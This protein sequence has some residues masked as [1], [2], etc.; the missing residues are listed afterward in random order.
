MKNS[1]IVV[2]DDERIVAK[3]IQVKLEAFGFVV[4]GIA[5]SSEE[6]LELVT[7]E[8]PDLVLMDIVLRGKEDG[9]ETARRIHEQVDVPIVYLTAYSDS[10]TLERAKETGPYGYMLKPF[11]EKDLRVTVE[12]A[13]YKHQME[14]RLKEH[15]QWLNTTLESIGDGVIA[16][17]VT[18]TIKFMNPSAE[19]LTGWNRRDV[20]GKDL[21]DVYTT[22]SPETRERL[23]DPVSTVLLEGREVALSNHTMVRSR[24]GHETPIL[25]SGTPI[26]DSRGNIFGVVLAFRDMS[27]H[28]RAMDALRRSEDRYK[29]LFQTNPQPMWV[30]DKE[31]LAFL[32]VNPA[33][34]HSYGYTVEEFR[35]MTLKDIRPAEDTDAL[36]EDL[37][38]GGETRRIWRHKKKDGTL[39]DVEV[40][41][42]DL[43][44]EN[45][46][47]RVALVID[48]SER[49]KA[50]AAIRESEAR[51]RDVVDTARDAIFTMSR[52]AVITSLNPAFE[53]LTGFPREQWIGRSFT[54]LL[55][56]DDLPLA[57]K[58]FGQTI[59]GIHSP[60]FELRVHTK[61][62]DYITGEFVIAPR[63]S[64]GK[65]TGILGVARDITDRRKL[66]EHLRES[67]KLDSV[68]TLAGG[69]A[70]DF[71]NILG[72]IL[73]YSTLMQS[74]GNDPTTVS[75]GVD[76]ISKAVHRGAGVV[77]QLLTFARKSTVQ[78]EAVNINKV[79][80][81]IVALLK[82]TFPRSIVF[83]LDLME[84]PPQ[85]MG[86]QNQLDQ[87]LLNLS[88]NARDAMPGGGSL[89]FSTRLVSSEVVSRRIAG[90]LAGDYIRI[91]VSDT[92][93]GMDEE[94][95]AHVFEPFFT[96][97]GP[98]AGTGLGLSVVYGVVRNHH[99][100]V[101]VESKV[102]EGST[103]HI[104]LPVHQGGDALARAGEDVNESMWVGSET[105]LLIEDEIALL[106]LLQGF[107]EEKGYKVISA[108]TG[109]DG[110][111]LYEKHHDEIALVVTDVG[112][113][114]LSGW[115][116]Y[117]KM[118][119]IDPA[120]KVIFASGYLDPSESSAR[121]TPGLTQ[122]I[123]KPYHHVEVL[124]KIRALLDAEPI[125]N[126]E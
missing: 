47:A 14:R 31:T 45:H 34:V 51:Y 95:R 94:T 86:D 58:Q 15:E 10:Q 72:I 97:K 28:H 83:N 68:G 121:L 107:I 42:H 89:S 2:V 33:A 52:D 6:A 18:G 114:G 36:I 123:E 80:T 32:A 122:T 38:S 99:G 101:E 126:D 57:V 22:V 91:S 50:V 37:Q 111:A 21:R 4:P 7:R 75:S 35:S 125:K 115:K 20:L 1:R 73:G 76:A 102:G 112:L 23:P 25:Q 100:F 60:V 27:E 90:P 103:F 84:H 67:Q 88:L 113:P 106:E 70:H 63:M 55:H 66:E 78:V 71:N 124:K 26:K 41:A 19:A 96:T 56:A 44:L 46:E 48:V 11:K 40:W 62:G 54:N 118:Q 5:S 120:V 74:A 17:D 105:I 77:K 29:T 49:V 64:E 108:T 119:E 13:L 39:I 53:R 93:T 69:I 98:N 117:E 79:V 12:M 104:Y 8:R 65:V 109:L 30:F 110:L 92:G 61:S 43:M 85:I 116:L 3:N 9:I 24:T 16:T 81:E 59:R 82:E 87:T